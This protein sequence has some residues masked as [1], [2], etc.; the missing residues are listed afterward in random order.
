M[1]RAS[2]IAHAEIVNNPAV[3]RFLERCEM[4]QGADGLDMGKLAIDV[5]RKDAT[6]YGFVIAIDG[7]YSETFVKEGFPS[8]SVSFFNFGPLLLKMVDLRKMESDEFIDPIDFAKLK[9]I[10]RHSL[11]LPT[12]NIKIKGASS[13]VES[14]R[15]TI[16]EFFEQK[17]QDGHRLADAIA[18]LV[19]YEWSGAPRPWRLA[20]CPYAGCD[21]R[22]VEFLSKGPHEVPCGT[23][24]RPVWLTDTF[25]LH[26]V[27]DEEQGASGALGYLTNVLE[28][29]VL[30]QWIML[31]LR[32]KP[33]LLSETLFVKDGPLGFFG[34]TANLQ[35]PMQDLMAHLLDPKNGPTVRIVGVEKSGAF[36]DHAMAVEPLME[37]GS[38]LIPSDEYIRTR[39]TMGAARYG[40][41]TY[42]AGKAIF[43]DW[44]GAVY[45][46]TL[47]RAE[48]KDDHAPGDFNDL[49]G[50]LTVVSDLK[51]HMYENALLPV[52]LANKLV[53]LADFPSSQILRVFAKDAIAA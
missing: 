20:R 9:Q 16:H 12:R 4:P 33:S 42:Y 36:V 13:F 32:L 23:C 28:H 46:L 49:A 45:V 14:F 53:S 40:H 7:G 26:E 47:P 43:K 50:V 17:D 1:E 27:A 51:C 11:A 15:R 19:C 25:R 41:N 35:G 52:A 21:G 3:K 30:V 37:R 34:Q 5:E 48:Y 2:K 39:I 44:D 18:W 38:L 29:A 31:A 6:G 10:Q 24:K 22:D 8:A